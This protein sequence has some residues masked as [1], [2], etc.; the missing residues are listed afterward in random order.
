MISYGTFQKSAAW[1]LYAKAKGI[2]FEI[3][4]AVSDQLKKYEMAV[5]HA[6]ED[7]K[8][9]IDVQ[10]FIE[11]QYVDIFNDSKEYMGLITSWSIAPCSYL[12]YAGNIRREIGLVK[13]KDH[14]CCLMDG[15]WAEKKHFLKNDL[16]KVS[17]VELIYKSYHAAGME[18]PDVND[19]LKMAPPEDDCWQMYAK[20]CVKGLN[21]VEKTGTSARVGK[22]APKNISE[23]CAFVAAIRPGFRSMFSTFESRKPFS[24][25]VKQFDDLIQTEEMPNSF[26][27]YQE[28]IMTALNYAGIPMSECYTAIKNIAKKRVEK[29]LAYKDKF[30]TGF[31]TAIVKD[32][33]TESEAK[34]LSEKLWQIIEDSAQYSF[35]C[36]L[37]G[38]TKI[39]RSSQGGKD[40][41]SIGEMYH[42][43]TDT[44]YAK[45]TGHKDL[46]KK[47]RY[48]GYG[49]ALSLYEDGRIHQNKIVDIRPAGVRM[50]YR[51]TTSDG[52][53][54][55]CTDNHKF[56]TPNGEKR[57]DE[58]HIG[59]DLYRIGIYEKDKTKYAFTNGIFESN[60]PVKGQKG[61]QANPSG[62]TVVYNQ[63]RKECIAKDKPCTDCELPYSH[64]VRFEVHHIDFDRT[65]NEPS[66]Y[67]WLCCNCHKKRH[68]AAGRKKRYDKGIPSDLT[69]IISIEPLCEQ[70]TYDVEMAAP[71]HNFV[72]DNGLIVSNSHSYCVSLDSLYS[73]W[74]KAHYPL[75]FYETLLQITESK[76]DK[77]KLVE[78]KH[79]AEDYFNIIFPS[80]KFGQ[81]NRAI[82][83]NTENNS[84]SNSLTSIKNMPK[85]TSELFWQVAQT[86]PTT[87]IDV[88]IQCGNLHVSDAAIRMLAKIGYFDAFGNIP[89]I[90]RIIDLYDFFNKGMA[91]TVSKKKDLAPELF[92]I[93]KKYATDRNAKGEELSS[94][95]ITNPEIDRLKSELTNLKKAYKKA[96][97]ENLAEKITAKSEEI[98]SAICTHEAGM[99]REMEAYI[100][101][102]KIE[103]LDYANKIQNQIEI[104]GYVDL[105]SGKE[106]DRRKL[107]VEDIRPLK[108]K[109][110]GD[111]WCYR[112]DTRS[113][114]SGKTSSLTVPVESYKEYPIKKND[115]IS[116]PPGALKKN[117][118]GYWYLYFYDK[119][120]A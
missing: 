117:R 108:D 103:D 64:D 18:P 66:N 89:E 3:A 101:S 40:N 104:L 111:I 82:R 54:V 97:D 12:L 63:Y 46:M 55:D 5:K 71:N 7:E 57:C 120:Y 41:F 29:V 36:C 60:I 26:L 49:Y 35:N 86:K 87:M 67:A 9:T 114:G 30:I 106:E 43:K 21:Q 44:T 74:I 105:Y 32:G 38:D 113:I 31:T 53:T 23:M 76:G 58:L 2:P 33:K 78:I 72:L 94:Y 14:V 112:I 13:I 77:D 28:H 83:A 110:N 56:P 50:T 47:Y 37:T 27:L 100:L 79:E 16:L 51:I 102:K 6:E 75:A 84:I 61:F 62:D 48:K 11:P 73:A 8:D 115:I 10:D 119:V 80:F 4:N 24:Y 17:V 116:V 90:M 93:V 98:D 99:L 107:F 42:I 22:Y 95:T 1:K 81:D 34:M 68:Y 88:L 91:K 39:K 69:T 70:E 45:S 109:K 15:A 59:D 19:L 92:E 65:H 118:K 25:G 52:Q 96:P 85:A 20:G